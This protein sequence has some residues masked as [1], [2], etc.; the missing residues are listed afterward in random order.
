MSS[1][2]RQK[3]H[4]QQRL[5]KFLIKL[6]V[7]AIPLYVILI[8]GITLPQLQG[9]VAWI[10][11]H[12]LS[13]AGIQPSLNG[14]LISIPISNGTWAAAITWDCTAWKSMLAFFALV[15]ATDYGLREKRNGLLFFIPLIF[16][17][18]IVR[19]LFMFFYVKTFDLAGY[20][21]V[22]AI[23]WSWGMIIVILVFWIIWLKKMANAERKP[24]SI[25]G[26]KTN[27]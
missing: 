2:K 12:L 26:R 5:L 11:Y 4:S 15:M 25:R 1:R 9:A 7:F 21:A 10:T 24:V 22:H 17:V 19:I 23:V 13:A 8:S 27:I 6:N 20:Y 3:K 16:I 14:L 18:N